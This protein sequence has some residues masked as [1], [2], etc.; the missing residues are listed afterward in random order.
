M[1]KVMRTSFFITALI[2]MLW[3]GCAVGP[4]FKKP[5]APQINNYT[6]APIQTTAGTTNM[7]GGEPQRFVTGGDIPGEWWTLFHSKPL[8]DL[9]ELSLSN[10]PTLKAAQAA[11]TVARENVLAQ[12]GA[13]Y[14]SVTAAF[15]AARQKTSQAI[16]PTPN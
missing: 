14:P 13:Y 16:S 2:L 3:A 7:A 1:A 12:K 6:P 11:L 5:A 10:N 9:I 15:S 4:D 8:N